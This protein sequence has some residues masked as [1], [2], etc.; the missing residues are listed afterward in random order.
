[1]VVRGRA[2]LVT[3]AAAAAA[4]LTATAATHQGAD[5]AGRQAPPALRIG[6]RVDVAGA[7]LACRVVRRAGAPTLDCR[8]G[9][10]QVGSYGT[11]L[12][13]RHAMVVRF[14]RGRTARVVFTAAHRGKARRCH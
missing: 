2:A 8:R 9:G 7:A 4:G 13:E 1:V 10:R 6:D 12:S 11:L 5:A 3:A 14:G